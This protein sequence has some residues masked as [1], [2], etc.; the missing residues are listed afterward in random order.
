MAT[1]WR[2]GGSVE[3]HIE[4]SPAAVYQRIAD[5]TLTGNRSAECR[6]CAWLPGSEPGT[7]G[8]RFRGKNRSGLMRWSRMCEVVAAEPGRMF[9]FRTVPERFDPSR[10]DSTT[11]SYSLSSQG[12][13][14]R[15]THSYEITKPPIGVFKLLYGRL[16]PHH[17][18]M[19][20]RMTETLDALRVELDA[21]GSPANGRDA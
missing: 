2:V 20:P 1:K 10:A 5:V 12:T 17:R 16:L 19:R 11:W 15:V 6:S 9:A 3:C 18:D 21:S 8:A 14:T 4:A 13:G 7:V